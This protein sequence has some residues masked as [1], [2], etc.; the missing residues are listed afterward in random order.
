MPYNYE[1][2]P[3]LSVCRESRDIALEKGYRAWKMYDQNGGIREVMWNPGVDVVL[4]ERNEGWEL[5]EMDVLMKQ[6]PE[7]AKQVRSLEAKSGCG[8][9]I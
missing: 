8:N 1:S 6:Y 7:Q 9:L 3:L 4:F 5:R 2:P